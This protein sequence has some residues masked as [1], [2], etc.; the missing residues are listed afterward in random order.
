MA[1]AHMP[2]WLRCLLP[3]IFE[4]ELCGNVVGLALACEL[5]PGR[6]VF[7]C[8]D[9]QGAVG[10]VVRGSCRTELGRTLVSIFWDMAAAFG[11]SVWIKFVRS[12]LNC[13]DKPSM[14]FIRLLEEQR[15]LTAETNVGFPRLF[16]LVFAAM[17]D[18]YNAQYQRI[19]APHGCV[20]PWPRPPPLLHAR[21]ESQRQGRP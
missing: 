20:S 18:M 2:E 11:T 13:A 7:L 3:G 6:P 5:A 21:H 15:A 8:C 1:H 19:N 10:T 17:R 14:C 12:K 9:N 16:D 4:Y